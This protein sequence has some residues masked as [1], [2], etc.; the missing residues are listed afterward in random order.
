[1]AII[2]GVS[3]SAV[4]CQTKASVLLFLQAHFC[5]PVYRAVLPPDMRRGSEC[6]VLQFLLNCK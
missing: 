2:W 6:C 3:E 5:S 4:S 1:M